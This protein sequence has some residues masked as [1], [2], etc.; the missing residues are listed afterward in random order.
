MSSTV[1]TICYKN[2]TIGAAIRQFSPHQKGGEY[3][4]KKQP[5]DLKCQLK[6]GQN[7][8]ILVNQT[9]TTIIFEETLNEVSNRNSFM[10]R[11][12]KKIK[13]LALKSNRLKDKNSMCMN[14]IKIFCWNVLKLH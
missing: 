12:R 6:Q 4:K 10:F 11:E 1:Q 5:T 13:K 8:A 14:L 3:S 7:S 2:A 9:S